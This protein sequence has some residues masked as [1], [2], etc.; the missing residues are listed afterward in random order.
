MRVPQADGTLVALPVGED[1]ALM[2]SRQK[3]QLPSDQR[4]GET[5]RSP[6]VIVRTSLPTV[7]T[8]PMNS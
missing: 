1:D 6:V 7:S 3:T 5:A 2:P 8:I 4:N